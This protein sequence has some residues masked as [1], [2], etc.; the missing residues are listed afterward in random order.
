[1]KRILFENLVVKSAKG[2]VSL[3]LV[4]VES[5]DMTGISDVSVIEQLPINFDALILEMIR[6]VHNSLIN[7]TW[8]AAGETS[9]VITKRC[10]MI[11]YLMN[12]SIMLKD[13]VASAEFKQFGLVVASAQYTDLYIIDFII[14]AD[15]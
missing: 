1:M 12:A 2:N 15:F 10:G 4:K 6:G 5:S 7:L 9:G 11:T 13:V 8:H 3:L 14:V